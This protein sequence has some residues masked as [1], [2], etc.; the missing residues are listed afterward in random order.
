MTESHDEHDLALTDENRRTLTG[1]VYE[2]TM[3]D[4]RAITNSDQ[5]GG[6]VWLTDPYDANTASFIT[7][8]ISDEL[9][10]RFII[11]RPRLM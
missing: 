2:L 9:K 10:T 4:A 7:I 6:K 11:Q 8:P 3:D 1:D 5:V